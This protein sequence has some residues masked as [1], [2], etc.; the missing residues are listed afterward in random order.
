MAKDKVKK[1]KAI[2]PAQKT[3]KK[4]G[5]PSI[6]DNPDTVGNLK[7][8]FSIGCN[9]TE[10]CVFAEVSRD[11]FYDA[12]KKDPDFS[13]K[14]EKLKLNPV[15]KAKQTVFKDLENPQTARWLLERKASD[16]FGTKQT[17]NAKVE[18]SVGVVHDLSKIPTKTLLKMAAAAK[19]EIDGDN[20]G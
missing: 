19:V 11:A 5:R 16:E 3:K 6:L 1:K 4:M 20:E 8:A 10:A 12:L 9:I 13:D 2:K 15:I 17:I 14:I 7:F 18:G